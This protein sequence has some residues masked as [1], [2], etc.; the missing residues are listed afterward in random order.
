VLP[1][2]I[3][4]GMLIGLGG[5]SPLSL[6]KQQADEKKQASDKKRK[7]GVKQEKVAQSDD[8]LRPGGS[9]G[10]LWDA[11]AFVFKLEKLTNAVEEQMNVVAA[12]GQ[13][14]LDLS[15]SDKSRKALNQK[16][17]QIVSGFDALVDQLRIEDLPVF[18]GKFSRVFSLSADNE[19][20]IK[21]ETPSFRIDDLQWRGIKIDSVVAARKADRAVTFGM[22][23]VKVVRDMLRQKTLFMQV[24]RRVLGM[25]EPNFELVFKDSNTKKVVDEIENLSAQLKPEASVL[26]VDSPVMLAIRDQ[27]KE[28]ASALGRDSGLLVVKLG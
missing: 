16:F 14:A 24:K 17:R 4:E 26:E 23:R 28:L 7:P 2:V 3:I 10:L 8:Q 15:Q 22:E 13:E 11:M 5:Y 18:N 19:E 21:F 25:G 12:M 1:R 6:R 9:K 20:M 27:Q